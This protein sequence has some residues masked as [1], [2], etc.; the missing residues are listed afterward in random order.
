MSRSIDGTD[1]RFESLSD[2]VLKDK[3]LSTRT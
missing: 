3:E 1:I 2:R